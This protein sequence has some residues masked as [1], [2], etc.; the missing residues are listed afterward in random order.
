MTLPTQY[1]SGFNGTS[2][3]FN[4]AKIDRSGALRSYNFLVTTSTAILTAGTVI[5]LVPVR[6]GARLHRP[7]CAFACDDLDTGNAVTCDLGIVYDDTTN[8]TSVPDKYVATGNTFLQA[9]ATSLTLLTT[10]AADSYVATGDGWLALTTA[11]AS[12]TTV[13]TI[14]GVVAIAYDSTLL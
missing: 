7:G 5:G 3:D 2:N 11:T 9:A 4:K 1:P 8:N 6:K 14:H 12:T 10:D 13:G